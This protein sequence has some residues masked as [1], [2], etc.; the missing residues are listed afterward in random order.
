MMQIRNIAIIA[1]VDHGKTTL[2]DKI[3]HATKVFRDNQDTGELIMDS[4]DLE[5]ERGITIFSKNAAVQYEGVKINV[6]DTPGHSDFGGEVE[7]VLKM[8]DGVILLVDAFEGPMPQTRFVLQ[9]AL[10]LNLKPIVVINKVDKPNC[11]PDEVHDAVF[12]LFFNL[13]AT[14]EQLD[15]P[16]FYGSGKNGWF[17]T[18]LVQI[19]NINPLLD[20]IIQYVPEPKIAEGPLQMQITSLD[21]SSFLGRIAVGKVARGVIKENQQ[22]ALMQAGD[23]IKKMKIKELYVFEG[24]GKKK[25]SE[26]KAGDICAVVGL[27]EFNIGDTIADVE[28]PEALPV[29]S[30]DEP[31][32]SM[33]FSINNSPFFGREGKFVTSRHLRDRLMKETEKN[34]ALRVEDSDNADSFS[35]YG[36]GILHLGVLIETM[37]REGF[38]LT[39]GQPQVLIK[40]IN[41]V[42]S[43]PFEIL[44]VDVPAEYSGKVIDLVTQRKGEMHVMESKGEMQH[45][46]FEIPS[47]GL[48]GLRSNMLTSTAGEAVMAHRFSEYKP[49]KGPIP[50][51]NNGVLLNKT[52]DRTTGYSIDKLQDRGRFFVDP[53]EEVYAGQIIA[54]HI[55]PGDLVVNATEAKKLT[56]HR[57][58]GAD[59]AARIAPKIVMSLEECMEYIEFD[60]CIEC[61]P[62]SIRL[63]KVILNEDDRKRMSKQM[64][65]EAI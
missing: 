9:K 14:E 19:D 49:W 24:M 48:I 57:A 50:G 32:M 18:S 62:K 23:V 16:T 1:H 15:F 17:N 52:T 2:V 7:R 13:D 30:V 54:E 21:Y 43:E 12:E 34:L 65:Q 39:V 41:G 61:T 26:V 45:L 20:G 25:V 6:I 31:T 63:R 10:Q 42:K 64:A 35:V 44:V 28:N 53:G 33:Q 46:E 38:E 8:A 36:R 55:K 11:R 5:R 47:R 29:I 27:E 56:N 59:D 40:N 58:S 4:N 37:R 3:L 60:E 51:R 22:I